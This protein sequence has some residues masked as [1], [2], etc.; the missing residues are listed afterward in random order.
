MRGFLAAKEKKK[1]KKAGTR[2]KK[3]KYKAGLPE[4][5][6]QRPEVKRS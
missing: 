2:K 6:L 5:G 4:I 1:Q 3:Q